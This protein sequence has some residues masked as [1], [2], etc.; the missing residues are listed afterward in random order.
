M[1]NLK[2]RSARVVFFIAMLVALGMMGSAKAGI[3]MSGVGSQLSEPSLI[4]KVHK[5]CTKVFVC[6]YFAPATSCSPPPC[7]KKGHWEK[8]C[9]KT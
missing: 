3:W 2:T 9:V 6:E 8:S 1:A 7:C 4:V 5:H